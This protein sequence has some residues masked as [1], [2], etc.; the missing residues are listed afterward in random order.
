M[1]C[2]DYRY[3]ASN[4]MIQYQTES[5]H[6]SLTSVAAPW[7]RGTVRGPPNPKSL[8]KSSKKNSMKLVGYTPRLKNYVKIPHTL[9]SY[10]S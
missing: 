5:N 7:G 8:Q 1:F 2:R 4:N 3:A 9:L 6:I 10:F